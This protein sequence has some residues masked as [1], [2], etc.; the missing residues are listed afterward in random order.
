MYG[1]TETTIWS[2]CARITDPDDITIGR[3]IA[4]TQ[5]YVLDGRRA[6]VPTGVVGELYIGGDGLARGYHGRLELTQ[7][8]FV[9]N[10]FRP[11][12]MYRTGDL[13]RLRDDGRIQYLERADNQVKVRGYRIELGE[14][15]AVLEKHPAVK[16]PVVIV[17]DDGADKRLVAYIVHAEGQSLTGT[18]LRTYLRGA[19]PDYMIP[20]VFVEMDALPLTAN[21]KVN[22]SAL[23]DPSGEERGAG[24]AFE[25]PVTANEQ[26]VA[27]IWKS[28]LKI[29]RVGRQDNFFDLGGHSL[30]S[31][32]VTYQV[33]KATGYRMSAR[34]MIFQNLEQIAAELPAQ[35]PETTSAI[36][37]KAV[38][39]QEPVAKKSLFSRFRD[40]L[41]RSS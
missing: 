36:R 32:H 5:C 8:R 17:W 16:Q 15:E 38:E 22:R 39:P 14:I 24:R 33:E 37:P 13:V 23:P 27:D 10:P 21:G 19:L 12:R 35:T 4:N 6:P 29:E 11:G 7:D 26:L 9:D 30:L 28:V 18:E 3:P 34:A 40:R 31:A 20:H 25:P 2:T 1:P 41:R